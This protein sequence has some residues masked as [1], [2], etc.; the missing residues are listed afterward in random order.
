MPPDDGAHES[1]TPPSA[2]PSRQM[3]D[4]PQY[5][6]KRRPESPGDRDA[7]RDAPEDVLVDVNVVKGLLA[8]SQGTFDDL[9]IAGVCLFSQDASTS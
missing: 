3:L 4:G 6:M 1:P 9:A 5:A 7:D 2:P 8:R